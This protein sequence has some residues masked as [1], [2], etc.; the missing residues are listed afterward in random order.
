MGHGDD[1]NLS[2]QLAKDH[3][4]WIVIEDDPSRPMKVFWKEPRLLMH[5]FDGEIE[6]L[7]E[8]IR[9]RRASDGVPDVCLVDLIAGCRMVRE[10]LQTRIRAR[11]S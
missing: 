7:V 4:E 9:C 6:L 2:W 3:G 10:L 11:A 5:S 1:L 8:A